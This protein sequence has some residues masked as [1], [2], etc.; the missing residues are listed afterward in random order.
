MEKCY[1]TDELVEF[2]NLKPNTKY[3]ESTIKKTIQNIKLNSKEIGVKFP[4]YTICNCGKCS[5]SKTDFFKYIK[6]NC[7]IK[8][9]KPKD[10]C[11]EYNQQPVKLSAINF[12]D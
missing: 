4:G 3:K 5:I 6:S 11:Y 2:L 12:N 7:I 9:L 8:S 1:V 10:F